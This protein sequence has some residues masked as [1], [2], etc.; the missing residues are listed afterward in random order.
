[1]LP[2]PDWCKQFVCY[3]GHPGLPAVVERV[4]SIFR[5]LEEV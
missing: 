4:N 2:S 3:E 5:S 1:L